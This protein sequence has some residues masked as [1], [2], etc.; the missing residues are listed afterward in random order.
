MGNTVR[1]LED[2]REF[3]GR[4]AQVIF[5]NPFTPQ[6]S[7]LDALVGP[8]RKPAPGEHVLAVLG[9]VLVAQ[10]RKIELRG[11]GGLGDVAPEDRRLLE[12]GYLFHAYDRFIAPFDDLIRAQI[13]RG[14][15]PAAVPFAEELLGLLRGRGFAEEEVLR[16]VALF[17]QIRRAYYFIAQS[18]VGDSPSMKKLRHALWDD[19]FT[20]DMLAYRE[21]LWN[22][23]E[24]FSTLLLGETGTGKGSA[25]AAIGRSGLIP[26]DGKTHRF[27]SSF[28]SAFVAI[29]LSQ[30]PETLIESELFGHRKGAFTGAV[31]DHQGLFERCSRHGSLFLDEIGDLSAPVQLK[32]LNVIQDR[33]FSPVGS[34]RQLRFEGRV[35]AAT[36]RPVT[37]LRRA[38]RFRDDFFYRL[39]SDVIEVPPLRQ[40]LR[41]YP[42]ELDQ[43]VHL[44]LG[45]M[46]GRPS[47]E[48]TAKVLAQ[49]RE[50]LP[51]D[52]AWPGNVRELEQALRRILL[53]GAYGGEAPD[54]G[55]HDAWLEEIG[56]GRLTAEELLQRY[57]RL[58]HERHGTYEEVA[59]RTALD[60][61]TVKKYVEGKAGGGDRFA[62]RP[63]P[64][65][66]PG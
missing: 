56:A 20:S 41:E 11:V 17:Y 2:E 13:E 24:D 58:L 16:L 53:K 37:E 62:R 55:G 10:L 9:P 64:R 57:C 32:L 45:R 31:D 44:L 66:P 42:G 3:L 21:H 51:A 23:M 52:Y 19:V 22:R 48:L 50:S 49:L 25:A 33:I 43:L 47:E 18:L 29:N 12:Y 14:E 6:A 15:Q 59:R 35:I 65:L 26:F 34:R 63:G 38:G 8:G 36:N 40:R 54:R 27:T 28:T 7:Q 5:A 4:L 1:L 61:R 30:Y 60:R 39:S 46:T